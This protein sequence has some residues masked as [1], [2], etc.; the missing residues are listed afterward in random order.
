MTS[1]L[2]S[3]KI[4]RI[5]EFESHWDNSEKIAEHYVKLDKQVM[6]TFKGFTAYCLLFVILGTYLT[7]ISLAITQS[8]NIY[9]MTEYRNNR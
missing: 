1:V 4:C 6:K 5:I 9:I 8:T 3:E 2:Y 7:F